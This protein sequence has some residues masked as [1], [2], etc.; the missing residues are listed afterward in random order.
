MTNEER[1]SRLEGSYEHLATKAAVESVRTDVESA[2]ASLSK[3]IGDVREEVAKA[4]LSTV[5]WVVGTGATLL[6]AQ[7]AMWI[8]ILSRLP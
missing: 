8:Y 7:A 5:K 4:S 3:E 1:I 2:R 6:A